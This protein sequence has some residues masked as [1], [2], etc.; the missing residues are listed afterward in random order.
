[1][2]ASKRKQ[3]RPSVTPQKKKQPADHTK[4]FNWASNDRED[5]EVSSS[6]EE[7]EGDDEHELKKQEPEEDSGSDDENETPNEKR[8][9][10]AK[11][12]LDTLQNEGNDDDGSDE[13]VDA[14]PSG[15]TQD[16]R[17]AKQLAQDVLEQSGK[18]FHQLA[19]QCSEFE[20][21]SMSCQK[22]FRGH[23][24]SITALALSSDGR[25]CYTASKDGAV[26]SWDIPSGKKHL[27]PA[28]KVAS[29]S[30]DNTQPKKQ[31]EQQR[32]I[33]AI[34]LS[35]D[36][37]LLVTGGQDHHVHVWNPSSRTHV[38][39]FRG[40]RDAVSCL[41]FRSRTLQL[42]SGS[43]D[44]C[45]KHWN[46]KEMGYVETLFGHQQEIMCL[47]SL[48]SE[49]VV[50]GSRDRSVR[51]WK[52]P[53]ETQLV[54]HD[55]SGSI[56]AL[57]MINEQYYVTGSDDGHV[58]LWF[59]GRKKPCCTQYQTHGRGNW[60]SSIAVMS[61]TDLVAT[62]SC[63]GFIRLWQVDL[64]KK[65]MTPVGEIPAVGFV[66]ALCFA[67]NQRFI[68]AG[69]GKEHRLG[70]WSIQKQAKNGILITALPKFVVE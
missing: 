12:Y 37:K 20:F 59:A 69:L 5:V 26:V 47:E 16:A 11:E 38:Q 8:I 1:M 43:F 56:D 31:T 51:V 41:A 21:D 58:S 14:S 54:F 61:G 4:A 7:Q 52:I 70:R 62:G 33:L 42:F 49:R 44:R 36:G 15:I 25:A 64:V 68:I 6:D 45:I 30:V 63:D 28:V 22:F 32:A 29:T 60:I 48:V 40:H 3:T 53:E 50:S 19:S 18:L 9:R 2:V 66:N 46:L 10:L 34:T 65:A 24:R 57:A 13:D 27:W 39:S 17:I 23:K 35:D 67:S 55:K